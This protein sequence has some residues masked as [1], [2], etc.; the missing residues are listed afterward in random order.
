VT[1][2]SQPKNGSTPRKKRFA[3]LLRWAEIG[4][5]VLGVVLLG[6]FIAMRMRS[7]D[8]RKQLVADFA[9]T[10][11]TRVEASTR[12]ETAPRPETASRLE[13]GD[14][15]A[16]DQTLWSPKRIA[17]YR[18]SLEV[19]LPAPLAVLRIPR[20]TIEVPVLPGTDDVTLD[21]GVGLIPG[22]ASPG[23]RGNS[24][25]AGH[26]DGFFRGLKDIEV[27]DRLEI[28][29]LKGKQEYAVEAM[30]IVDPSDVSV[31]DDTVDPVVTLVT[32]Y[33][34][35]YVG[36]APQRFIV[37]ARARPEAAGK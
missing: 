37:R 7:E 29:T 28:E 14:G 17:H 25:I 4:G 23:D 34:F 12:V 21:R 1:E 31:L 11:A 35:Y 9:A 3:R 19:A 27:G 30:T 26:R 33:P 32:C 6:A 18:D 13:F 15:A 5:I 20:L 2:T 22:T 16:V 8:S 10:A 36:K 24:A